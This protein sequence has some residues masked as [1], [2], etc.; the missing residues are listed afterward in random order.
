MN[1]LAANTTYTVFLSKGYTPYVFTGWNVTGSWEI[2]VEY[3]GTNYPETLILA[4]TGTAITGI[5]LNTNP[6]A[7]GSAFTI[8]DGSVVGDIINIVADHDAG[9]LVVH[10]TGTIA[11][12]GSMS[13]TWWDIAPGTRTGTWSSTS[14][15]AVKTHT[16]NTSWNGFFTA[17]IPAFTF[18]TDEFGAGSWHVN[19]RDSDFSG[20]ATYTLSVWVNATVPNKTILISNNF[21]VVVD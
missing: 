16:G 11:G 1:G 5:S 12:D 17:T 14:G 15:A 18:T 20:P 7:A 6:P 4:Q 8:I 10:L 2:N 21:D 9:S 13:G 19:M 3:L